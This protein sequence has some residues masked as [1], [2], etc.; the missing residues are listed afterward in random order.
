MKVTRRPAAAAGDRTGAGPG[1]PAHRGPARQPAANGAQRRPVA[2]AARRDA[3]VI[4]RTVHL[5]GEDHRVVGMMPPRSS[6]RRSGGRR[7]GGR[8]AGAG[9]QG[10]RL[11]RLVPAGVRRGCAGVTR[12]E[13]QAEMNTIWTRLADAA[14]LGRRR[15]DRGGGQP[16][17]EGHGRR[18]A[19]LL[20]LLAAVGLRAADRLRQPRQPAAGPLGLAAAGARGPRPRSA[21]AAAACCARC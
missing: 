12:A 4:G 11:E 15:A 18:A 6:S 19:P 7:R 8:A 10:E 2:A 14:P 17:E 3:G 1:D 13:A 5:D 16:G 20:V 21:P 9:G